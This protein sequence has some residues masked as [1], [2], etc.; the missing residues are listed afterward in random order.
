MSTK[1]FLASLL[2]LLMLFS[3]LP[4]AALAEEPEEI[5]AETGEPE[6]APPRD[7]TQDDG[8]TGFFL[9][10][11]MNG[12][13]PAEEYRFTWESYDA[14]TGVQWVFLCTLNVG[15]EFK[16]VQVENSSIVQWFPDNMG[17]Y[18]VDAAHAGYKAVYLRPVYQSDSAFYGGHLLVDDPPAPKQYQVKTSVNSPV[19]GSLSVSPEYAYEGDTVTVTVTPD[20]GY[21]LSYLEG[22]SI[23][24]VNDT[25]YTTVMPGYDLTVY[26]T[27]KLA[28]G[29]Y[30]DNTGRLVPDN[31]VP[32]EK[33]SPSTS[34]FGEWEREAVL[35]EGEYI[36]VMGVY[37]PELATQRIGYYWC[38]QT[39]KLTYSS[40]S[41]RPKVTAEQAGHAMVFLTETEREGYTKAIHLSRTYMDPRFVWDAWWIIKSFHAI[42][43]ETA[44]N[45][46]VSADLTEAYEGQT[47]TLTATPAAGYRLGA[48]TV[49]DAG[50]S[51][52][53][54]DGNSFAMPD[55]PV[56]VTAS[57]IPDGAATYTVIV[58]ANIQN[59]SVTPDKTSAA[60][61]EAV[62]LT[63]TPDEGYQ[64]E[65][66]T[67]T[68]ANGEPVELNG[69]S[70][71]MPA[72]NV[73][74]TATFVLIPPPTYTV[75]VDV[76]I[77]N[78]SVTA[79]KATALEGETVSLTV[80][81]DPGYELDALTVTA[82]DGSPVA[83]NGT[84]F[85]MP[86]ANVTVT[87]TFVPV[88]YTVTVVGSAEGCTVVA[89]KA[90]AQVGETVTITVTNDNDHSL[91]SLDA[92]DANGDPVTLIK[93]Q[94]SNTKYTFTM[95]AANVTVTAVSRAIYQLW[96]GGIQ[97]GSDN[98]LDILGDGSASY[99]PAARVLSFSSAE[100]AITGEYGGNLITYMG[101]DSLT[102][103]APNG[104]H[105]D[106]SQLP[107]A[108][109][110]IYSYYASF[111][112][113]GDLTLDSPNGIQTYGGTVTV[114]GNVTGS[115]TSI[116]IQGNAGVT[117]NGDVTT[118]AP[119]NA[120][121]IFSQNGAVSISGDFNSA[122]NGNTCIYAA[123]DI[124]IGGDAAIAFST[125]T[126]Q[127]ALQS[128]NGSVSVGGAFT[129]RAKASQYVVSA[130]QGFT[131][132]GD[133]TVFNNYGK[134]VYSANG[135]ITVVSGIWNVTASSEPLKAAGGIIIPATHFITT[136][137]G[138]VVSQINDFA[139]V[140]EADGTTLAIQV[141]IEPSAAPATVTVTFDAGAGTVEPATIAVD[142]GESIETLPVPT[143]AGGWV[144]M[145]WY[146]EPAATQ[147]DICQ[148]TQVTAETT[149]DED[150]TVYAHWRLPGDVN[151]DGKVN[152]TDVT[153]LSTYV[154]ARGSGVTIVPFSGNIDGDENDKVNMTDVTLLSTF[155]KARGSGV[156]IH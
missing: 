81:P 71:L 141:V 114:N 75:A 22:G 119:N 112:I 50:G 136:P 70:F 46:A 59:G 91:V 19:H 135:A 37:T 15:D 3:L 110:S 34:S 130:A 142:V 57:F 149:F 103:E 128:A 54:V 64:L 104:L 24:K 156:T 85:V 30:F 25:T 72:A 133:V 36:D 61:G 41:D 58:D 73:T 68:D 69:T 27:F 96:V 147:F 55:S 124:T 60:E 44:E 20:E 139:V 18:V 89:D 66:L 49:L 129:S 9:V 134:G 21:V 123:G 92:V 42:T 120:R 33:F 97:V 98:Y 109:Q 105:L 108:T 38:F 93:I 122:G 14:N 115:G 84:S 118:T 79:D 53:P 146:L 52:I 12:W 32:E 56:T 154:K 23:T 88:L 113:N 150:T 144:F 82:A 65:T 121:A 43:V 39:T 45:G 51:E 125:T 94:Y 126:G 116:L 111:V 16:A 63:V 1:R 6:A 77:A 76:N 8:L 131:C 101:E 78:G 11:S 10:G 2:A 138:G 155:V 5:A 148:G 62:N 87:A 145:G 74:V 152:M 40:S 99:D 127:Y 67:V 90:T 17:N 117:V 28:P 140:T 102:I 151:G 26:A 13:T 132:A 143:R 107:S 29:F 106:A 48:F 83:L 137:E 95:P 80:T 86:A 7:E 47:V 35:T 153:L 31:Y 4:A 100:P